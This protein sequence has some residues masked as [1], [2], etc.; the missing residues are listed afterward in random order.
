MTSE[1]FWEAL[2]AIGRGASTTLMLIGITAI[3]GLF[4]S[5]IAAAAKRSGIRVLR[6]AVIAYVELIRNTPFLVQL[7]FVFFGLPALGLRLDPITAALLAMILNMTAYTTEVIGAGLDAVPD[8]QHDAARALGLRP[9]VAFLKI[10]LP[11]A[12]VVIYPALVSQIIIM[13][14]ESAVVSQIAVRELTHE[15]ELW[16]ARTFRAF[17]TYFVIAMVYLV[18][19]IALRRA[20]VFLGK[21]YLAAGIT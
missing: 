9:Y 14:L 16:Q 1:M 17:E 11:Q 12:L 20:L 5:I 15:A 6:A 18:M 2:A 8:G 7:F 19:S 3:V 10:I 13:M 4:L 21:R